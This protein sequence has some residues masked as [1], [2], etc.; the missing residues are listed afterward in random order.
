MKEVTSGVYLV[1]I[2]RSR[3]SAVSGGGHT[4]TALLYAAVSVAAHQRQRR[5][6]LKKK[7]ASFLRL[8]RILENIC[9]RRIRLTVLCLV[10]YVCILNLVQL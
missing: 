9:L 5:H 7:S 8:R 10:E 2:N 3:Y 6:G 4:K 1:S